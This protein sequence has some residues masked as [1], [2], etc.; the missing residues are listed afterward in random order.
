MTLD[1]CNKIMT[2]RGFYLYCHSGDKTFATYMDKI[3]IN[4]VVYLDKNEFK[5]DYIY[6]LLT[7][8]T[9]NVGCF[10]RQEQ[11]EMFYYMMIET[12]NKLGVI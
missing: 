2:E 8:T 7:L 3:G 6:K 1:D 10:D 4:C 11:F 9:G 5:F 12:V